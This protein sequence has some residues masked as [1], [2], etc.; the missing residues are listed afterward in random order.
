MRKIL[1]ICVDSV[2][3]A[4]ASELGGAQRI[5]LCSDLLEGGITP[6]V[7]LIDTVRAHATIDLSVMIRPRGGDF[8]F[9]PYEFDAMRYDIVAAKSLG[10]NGVVL[11]LLHPDGRIDV[12]RT[13]QLV[14]LA[15]PMQVTFHRAFDMSANL[16]ESLEHVIETGVDRILTSGSRHAT[17]QRTETIAQLVQ[18]AQNK[19]S[20]MVGGGVRQNNIQ[21]IAL[22]SGAKE[23]HC[24]LRT[25]HE[26]PAA[27][28]NPDSASGSTGKN[29]LGRFIVLEEKVRELRQMLDKIESNPA[30]KLARLS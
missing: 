2:E 3:S 17:V 21:K 27:A 19:V 26:G 1:E 25:W 13:R 5:E 9:T 4:I 20:I 18:R 10:A 24:S 8:C 22:G 30:A 12:D 6:S 14:E 16:H 29:D 28:K 11:G 15:R 23:F 7:G